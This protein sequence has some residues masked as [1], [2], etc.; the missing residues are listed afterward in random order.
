MKRGMSKRGQIT[1]FIVVAV[2]IVALAGIIYLV[3]P[4]ITHPNV[5]STTP[6]E[7][8]QDCMENEIKEVAEEISMHG[9]DLEPEFYAEYFEDGKKYTVEYL[10]Y[11][12]E[13]YKQ[14][15]MQQPLLKSHIESEIKEAIK[16]KATKCFNNLE[17]SYKKKG[18]EVSLT[19]NDYSVELLP[20]KIFVVFDYPLTLTKGGS[21]KYT[22]FEV[23]VKS[24]LYR[25]VTIAHKILKWEAQYGDSDISM[26]MDTNYWLKAEKKKKTD[27]TKIY[28]LTDKESNERFMFASRSVAWPPGY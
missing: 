28:I 27:G 13:Y 21:D 22:K 24:N 15:V 9:G 11:T 8:I 1:I 14:C 10:C 18:Y 2:I 7:Y 3:Y 16:N 26:Y 20:N 4:K 5:V 19:R 25:L 17:E 6:T 23:D 12:K